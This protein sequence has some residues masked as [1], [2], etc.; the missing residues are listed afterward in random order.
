MSSY[1]LRCSKNTESKSPKIV[2]NK[3]GRIMLLSRCSVCNSKK[4]KFLIQQEA[5]GLLSN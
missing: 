5:R 2:R 4:L 1:Y 3:N